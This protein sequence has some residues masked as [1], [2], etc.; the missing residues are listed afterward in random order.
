MMTGA[1][2]FPAMESVI[3]GR[4]FAEA[5]K[6]EV[7]RADAHAVFLLASGTLARETDMVEQIRAALGNRF[8]GVHAKIGS[9]TP[10]VDCVA[11]ANAARA[12]GAD[13]IVTLGGGSVTDAAKIVA[14]C[15]ANNVTDAAQLDNFRARVDADGKSTRPHIEAPTLRT[16]AIPTTLS[17][18][19]YTASAGCTD[20]ARNVKES[21][22]HPIMMAKSVLLDPA[23]TV[24]TPEWLFLSTGIRA[25]DHAVEDICSPLCQPLSEGSSAQALKLLGHGLRGVKAEPRDLDARLE[26]QLGAWMS[27][28]GSQTGVPKGASHGIGHVLGGTARVPHGYTSCVML[29]HVLRFNHAVNAGRQAL[30]SDALGDREATAADLVAGLI[31][32]LGLPSRLRD[33]GVNEDQLDRIAELSMHDRWIHTNPKKIDG[34]AIIRQILDAAW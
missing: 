15:L 12:A 13:L 8:A 21:Y 1:Y 34:P 29:P 33:V 28:I 23:A 19:E 9:H 4:P 17:A 7:E 30:V 14:M 11:A 16:I 32:D 20:T 6:E 25:V 5:L 27:M 18:G 22:G 3:Y 10:R 2:R 31:A 26:C 24:H